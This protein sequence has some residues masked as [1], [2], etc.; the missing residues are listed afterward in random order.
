MLVWRFPMPVLAVGSGPLGGG[1]GRREWL[2]N[3]TVDREYART[4]PDVHLTELAAQRGLDG[5]G[6]GMLTAFDVSNAVTAEDEQ[7]SA[8]ATVGLG[9][10]VLAAARDEAP[11]ATGPGTINMVV[12]V[13]ARLSD[14]ALVNAVATA[15]E[16]KVQA[17]WEYGTHAT[18]TASDAVFVVC[19]ADGPA[20]PYGGPRSSWGARVAR[21]VHAAV[22]DGTDRW[23][24]LCRTFRS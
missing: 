9:Y 23:Y 8:V 7:V 6:G 5:P 1:F 22:L 24:Q 18:G 3:A 17:L 19:P 12:W 2:I 13:P 20:E 10:P 15:T 11:A 21:A 14:A 4:D 16:A